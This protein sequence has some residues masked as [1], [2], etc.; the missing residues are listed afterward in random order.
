MSCFNDRLHL[1]G[2]SALACLL[3]YDHRGG[4]AH[5]SLTHLKLELVFVGE[6]KKPSGFVILFNNKSQKRVHLVKCLVYNNSL[7]QVAV[8]A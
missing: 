6:K 1:W 2:F 5:F 7:Q 4:F 3:Q 8:Q